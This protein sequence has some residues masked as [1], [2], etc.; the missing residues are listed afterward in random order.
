MIDSQGAITVRNCARRE[1]GDG[2]YFSL[3]LA[4]R[5]GRGSEEQRDKS[6]EILHVFY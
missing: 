6:S 2:C 1:L 5:R 3:S 4:N